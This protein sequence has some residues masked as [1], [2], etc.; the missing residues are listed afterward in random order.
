MTDCPA[1]AAFPAMHPAATGLCTRRRPLRWSKRPSCQPRPGRRRGNFQLAARAGWRGSPG[2]TP[3]RGDDGLCGPLLRL[4]REEMDIR[5][6]DVRH[7]V[8]AQ[9]GEERTSEWVPLSS[10]SRNSPSFRLDPQI[11]RTVVRRCEVRTY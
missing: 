5:H 7:E 1:A 3:G 8:Q 6:E 4:V 2:Q 11:L 9:G 10:T